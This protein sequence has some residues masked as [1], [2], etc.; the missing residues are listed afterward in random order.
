MKNMK[1][2]RRLCRV[3]YLFFFLVI[4]AS[5]FLS[6]NSYGNTYGER[7]DLK[8]SFSYLVCDEKSSVADAMKAESEFTHLDDMEPCNL[9]RL[10]G[11]KGAYLWM[12][13]EFEIPQSLKQKDL[14]LAIGFL[15]FASKTWINGVYAG[16]YGEFPPYERSALFVSHFYPF[17]QA[18]LNRNGK[19]TV[20]IK[21]WAH[22]K[23]SLSDRVF[24]AQWEEAFKLS[25]SI[26]F[27]GTKIYMLFVGGMLVTFILYLMLFLSRRK[28]KAYLPFAFI[29][30]FTM[31][32]LTTFFAPEVPLYVSM[33]FNYLL[34][35]KL[36]LCIGFYLL[37]WAI[38]SFVQIYLA[39]P[40]SFSD[41]LLRYFLLIGSIV[42]T[43]AVPDYN[44]LMA[45]CPYTLTASILHLGFAIWEFFVAVFDKKRRRDAIILILGFAPVIVAVL[46]DLIVRNVFHNTDNPY[47]AIFGL[48]FSLLVFIF[49]L[50]VRYSKTYQINENLMTNLSKEVEAK[51]Q[52]LETE[53]ERSKIDLEMASIV[54]QKFFP[55]PQNEFK[56]WDIAVCY[57]PCAKVSGD[58]FDYYAN[59]DT[60]NGLSLFDVS[61][62]GIASA[63]IT[64]LSKNIIFRAFSRS[65][66]SSDSVSTALFRINREIIAI[67][68]NIENYLTG[69]LF[70]FNNFASSGDCIVEMANAGHPCPIL[71]CAATEEIKE[72]THDE[73]QLQYGAIGIKGIDVSFPQVN[74]M[75][76]DGDVLVCYTD[77]LTEAMNAN[78][79]LFGKERAKKIIADNHEKTAC[80]IL[81]ALTSEVKDFSAGTASDDD[82]TII[83]LRRRNSLRNISGFNME[84]L[85]VRS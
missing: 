11:K 26:T 14:G 5:F 36:F 61:G 67:K 82:M 81:N 51:T 72:I 44:Y 4:C 10:V 78:R 37:I 13:C 41:A 66:Y 9:M 75:M 77:G 17:P 76:S 7:I 65:V 50:T 58:L 20:L 19:N 31:I 69:L 84:D 2:H 85:Y 48:Q 34:F 60:L 38:T 33:G 80:E 83:V 25:E 71:F 70:H 1:F 3:L 42:L 22:G 35:M 12:K 57:R 6:C 74:F 54:Q 56:G 24:I 23:S 68:G 29:S 62:H 30:F 64:M 16:S 39:V 8:N 52:R 21:V 18:A 63:L 40:F 73:D 47:F 45:I 32:F 15:R 49:I 27:N 55:L 43:L 53:M 59:G 28:D 46:L 79:E